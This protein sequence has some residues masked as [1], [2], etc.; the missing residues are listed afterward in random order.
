MSCKYEINHSNDKHCQ[1]GKYLHPDLTTVFAC[2]A[3]YYRLA[4]VTTCK[5]KTSACKPCNCNPNGSKS[6]RCKDWTGNCSC[7]SGFYGKRCQNRDCS[8]EWKYSQCSKSCGEVGT[9]SGTLKIIN[10]KEGAGK[11]CPSK[12]RNSISCFRCCN[13]KF[14]CGPKGTCISSSLRCNYVNDCGNKADE[15]YC[16]EKCI[17]KH[18]QWSSYSRFYLYNLYPL[19]KHRMHCGRRGYVLQKFKLEKLAW[20]NKIRYKYTCCKLFSSPAICSNRVKR[21]R[22]SYAKTVYLSRQVVNCGR[23]SLINAVQLK[24]YRRFIR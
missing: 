1:N 6:L 10:N 20:T 21:S 4:K 16:S 17:I 5:N 19:T 8:F 3:N 15:K 23:G 13:K 24:R 14:Q 7:K 2:R 22:F 12:K 9:K 18:T 11:Q